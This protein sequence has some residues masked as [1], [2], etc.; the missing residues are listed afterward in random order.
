MAVRILIWSLMSIQ[1]TLAMKTFVFKDND[2]I[3]TFVRGKDALSLNESLG[4]TYDL[5]D[6][7]R[8][9]E[10][11]VPIEC[12]MYVVVEKNYTINLFY[13]QTE[14]AKKKLKG[15]KFLSFTRINTPNVMNDIHKL[16]GL[17][18]TLKL[19]SNLI[20]QGQK[21]NIKDSAGMS[22]MHHA[23]QRGIDENVGILS[24]F[25]ANVN[26]VNKL[27]QTPLHLAIMNGNVKTMDLLIRLGANPNLLD[28]F[29]NTSTKLASEFGYDTSKF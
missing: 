25:D 26:A 11:G 4:G 23:A 13:G 6:S 22:P 3:I 27:N 17:K 14:V 7:D 19:I 16:A 5:Y 2:G 1:W 8:I 24:V 9:F 21:V 29:G 15:K 10:E 12:K 18:G 20:I 28:V